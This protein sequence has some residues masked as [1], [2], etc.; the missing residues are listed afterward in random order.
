MPDRELIVP[1][2]MQRIVDRAGFVPAVKVGATV[3]C[4]GRVGRTVDLEVITDP[5]A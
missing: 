3:F 4:A 2:T 1:P 5:E